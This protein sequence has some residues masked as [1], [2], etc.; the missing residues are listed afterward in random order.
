MAKPRIVYLD[1]LRV[2]ACCMVVLMHSPHPKAGLSAVLEVPIYYG[3]AAGLCLFFMVSGALLLPAKAGTKEFL[4]RR[5][6]KIIG[7]LLVWTIFYIS[8]NL[9][10]GEMVAQDLPKS[11]LSIPFSAQG[12]GVLWFMYTLTGLYLLTPILSPFL[13]KASRR[14]LHFY[15]LLWIISMCYPYIAVLVS[16]NWEPTGVLYYFSGFVGYFLM[17]YYLNHYK[18]NIRSLSLI[19]MLVVP[20]LV[21]AS[22]KY[23]SFHVNTP[24]D[25]SYL[26][27]LVLSMCITWF[28]GIRKVTEKYILQSNFFEQFLTE[29]S[30][31]CFG[32]YLMHRLVMRYVLWNCD[33]IVYSFGGIGQLVITWLLTLIISFV[34]TWAISHLPYSE[35]IIGYRNYRKKNV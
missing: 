7:P 30:N 15:L 22:E 10:K 20:F 31:A 33:F 27:I 21:L 12:F 24:F 17:G 18:P 34:I 19:G 1:I 16:L 11:L 23:F 5:M 25:T 2:I 32:I 8:L 3:T 6:G 26:N 4:Q 35:Y 14:E 9:V 28:V 29:L 13:Q